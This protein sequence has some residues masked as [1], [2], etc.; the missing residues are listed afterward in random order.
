MSLFHPSQHSPE[1][2]G[3]YLYWIDRDADSTTQFCASDAEVIRAAM[4]SA[5][6]LGPSFVECHDRGSA[7][8][9][10]VHAEFAGDGSQGA[11]DYAGHVARIDPVQC[12][13][14]D[15][16]RQAV[17][18]ECGHMLGLAHIPNELG[19]AVMNP[20]LCGLSAS[21]DDGPTL[22]EAYL[23]PRA[24]YEPTALDLAEYNRVHPHR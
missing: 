20:N 12:K 1:R 17:I 23:G 18:H 24:A 7:H 11:A 19:A 5:E 22:D 15:E 10:F 6:A 16:K 21:G 14:D 9:R 2:C 13:G 8:I 3:T 4:R